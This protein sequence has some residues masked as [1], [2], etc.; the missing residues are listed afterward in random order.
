MVGARNAEQAVGNAAA[1]DVVLSDDVPAELTAVSES[2]KT[3]L[4]TN[5]DQWQVPSRMERPSS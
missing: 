4:G 1:G 5:C 2:A 3:A